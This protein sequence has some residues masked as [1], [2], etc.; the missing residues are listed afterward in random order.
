MQESSIDYQSLE[1]AKA[2]EIQ[3]ELTK[4]L[5]QK[6]WGRHDSI[7]HAVL[8]RVVE[9]EYDE[10]VEELESYVQS[11][12]R[13]PVF[14]EK[15]QPYVKHCVELAYAIRTKRNFT[16]ISSMSLSKQ[17]EIYEKV[18]DHFEELKRFLKQI[19]KIER[20]VRL[21]DIRSTVWVLQ[22]LWQSALI[23]LCLAF[24]LEMSTGLHK[25]FFYVAN[26]VVDGATTY[27]FK[28]LGL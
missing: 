2:Q 25:S 12:S 4:K 28:L 23:I 22:A 27:V 21:V 13:Y 7:R 18:V 16:G 9:A 10:A 3:Q 24:F 17:Q 15:C 6:D 19:E 8:R 26:S 5:V 11:Q 1:N 14:Q 20:D